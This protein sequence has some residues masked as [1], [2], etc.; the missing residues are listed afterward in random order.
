MKV[1]VRDSL[2]AREH[3]KRDNFVRSNKKRYNNE[4]IMIAL[5][6]GDRPVERI[7]DFLISPRGHS[8]IR[9]A[10]HKE[11]NSKT[12]TLI[13]YIDDLLYHITDT[14]YVDNWD[15]KARIGKINKNSYYGY[16]PW[17]KY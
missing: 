11:F 9:V 2:Q 6:N 1:E 5:S 7:G 10:W 8:K 13:I 15:H 3:V 4:I 17:N 12:D 16:Q 14:D